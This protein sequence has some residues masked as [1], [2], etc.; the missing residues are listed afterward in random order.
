MR[1]LTIEPLSADRI[2]QAYPLIQMVRPS[3]SFDGWRTHAGRLLARGDSGILVLSDPRGLILGLV[4]WQVTED[5]NHGR[6]LTAEDFVALD[7]VDPHRVAEVLADALEAT[8]R[9]VGCEAVHTNVA[10]VG[11]AGAGRLVERL[12]GLGHHMESFRLCKQLSR[13]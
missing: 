3:L 1:S 11:G 7:I 10:C 4:C 5:A 2:D 6:T 13:V 12:R 8:A 9:E